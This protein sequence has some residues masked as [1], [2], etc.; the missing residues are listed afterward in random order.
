MCAVW[1]TVTSDF[2]GNGKPRPTA[3]SRQPRQL[4]DVGR[5]PPRLILTVLAS[6]VRVASGFNY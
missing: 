1:A 3:F 4:G 6:L 5:N 2:D